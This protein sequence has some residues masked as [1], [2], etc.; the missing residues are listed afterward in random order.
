MNILCKIKDTVFVNYKSQCVI[1]FCICLL[2]WLALTFADSYAWYL[3]DVNS[4]A[5]V[6]LSPELSVFDTF[7]KRFA[8]YLHPFYLMHFIP[9]VMVVC[10]KTSKISSCLWVIIAAIML[11][12]SASLIGEGGD[13]KGCDAC[14]GVA[15]S[16]VFLIIPFA[17]I[18]IITLVIKAFYLKY[19]RIAL[20]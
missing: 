8:G 18:N 17:G 5:M 4:S 9:F 7:I 6:G 1:T 3:L 13:R 11:I 2:S 10:T 15:Y 14:L 12:F 19:R 20:K 16:Y